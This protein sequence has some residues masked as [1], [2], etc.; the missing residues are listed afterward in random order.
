[1][2]RG[3]KRR[4]VGKAARA[5]LSPKE[6]AAKGTRG[7]MVQSCYLKLLRVMAASSSSSCFLKL[8]R[9]MAASSSSKLLLKAPPSYGRLLF[10]LMSIQMA[11]FKTVMLQLFIKILYKI[12][13]SVTVFSA[14]LSLWPLVKKQRRTGAK[15]QCPGVCSKSNEWYAREVGTV[16]RNQINCTHEKSVQ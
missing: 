13:N 5:R 10:L 7:N 16:I 9:V 2:R 1:M 6:G 14:G 8:L 12:Y 15:T 3:R 11:S 4:R